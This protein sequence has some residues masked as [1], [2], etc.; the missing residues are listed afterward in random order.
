M[1]AFA[2]PLGLVLHDIAVFDAVWGATAA[3]GGRIGNNE[4][5]IMT[6]HEIGMV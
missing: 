6:D 2:L 3:F 5:A 4:M 1:G